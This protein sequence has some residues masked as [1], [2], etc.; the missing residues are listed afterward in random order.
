MTPAGFPHSDTLGS[1]LGWQLPEAYRSLPR[2]S[3]APDAK[4]STVCPYQLGHKDARVHCVILKLRATPPPHRRTPLHPPT[5]G[6][7]SS[8][9]S[10]K[11]SATPRRT[12]TH[13]QQHNKKGASTR[14]SS[15]PSGP[16]SVLYK[17]PPTRTLSTP[18]HNRQAVLTH[19]PTKKLELVNVP[20]MSPTRA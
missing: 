17:P 2:P 12:T 18:T 10:R 15:E 7:P 16:N 1:Q 5:T 13:T 6:K 8:S 4:A 9:P 19:E 3:S 14:N 20:P 11:R